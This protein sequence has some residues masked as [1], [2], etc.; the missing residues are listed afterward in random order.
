MELTH[1]EILLLLLRDKIIIT[2]HHHTIICAFHTINYQQQQ[3]HHHHHHH[4]QGT[5]DLIYF[6]CQNEKRAERGRVIGRKGGMEQRQRFISA[7]MWVVRG[8]KHD[9]HKTNETERCSISS[10][11]QVW[12]HTERWHCIY[13]WQGIRVQFVGA[14]RNS[15]H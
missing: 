3:Q 8:A 4:H 1:H 13:I 15:I 6:S 2:N 5:F 10:R 7:C 12:H 14:K 9:I 11:R